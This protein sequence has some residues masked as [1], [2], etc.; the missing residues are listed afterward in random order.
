MN[1]MIIANLVHRPVRTIISIIAIAVEVTLI[2]LIVGLSL[3]MLNDSK[4][5]TLG[6][7]ADL[8]AQP[9]GS[10]MLAGLSGAPAPIKVADVLRSLP[11][12]TVVA[13]VIWQ[14]SASGSVEV[15]S[16]IDLDT[17][18]KLG[19]PFTFLSGG[20]FQGPFDMIVDDYFAASNNVKVGDTVRVLNNNF[21]ISGI[22]LHGKGGRRFFPIKTL[23]SLI[24]AEGKASIFYVKLDDPDNA[25]TVKKEIAGAGMGNWV[26]RSMPE[27]LS[28]MTA[29]NVPGLSQFISV[30]ISVAVIIGF[31][32]IFQAM[33]TAVMERTREIGILKSM[34]A[35]K[36]YIVNV[37]LRETILLA[38]IGI[39]LGI[40]FSFVAKRGIHFKFPL[41]PIQIQPD[42][43]GYAV[44]IAI[45][46]AILGALYPAFK[47]AQ[48]D[49]IEALA[50]E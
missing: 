36:I 39:A 6:V 21:R 25:E 15:L 48:K 26:V 13:P 31:I 43:I 5:R 23:Q 37:V 16:G 8:M 45:V 44:L 27:Y 35:S 38:L 11:H 46:G 32:V 29:S 1:K 2:L 40:T 42:W 24:G 7:G 18:Q 41:L 28:M 10:Q 47:A 22:V 12:V 4:N 3:G 49:P 30:V 9:P 34:G 17:Y 20:P 14:L 19:S 50:Y 33:Y